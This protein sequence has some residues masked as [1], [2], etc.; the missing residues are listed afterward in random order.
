MPGKENH[1]NT[2]AFS[3]FVSFWIKINSQLRLLGASFKYAFV[4]DLSQKLSFPLL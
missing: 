4:L 1:K 3:K 2:V